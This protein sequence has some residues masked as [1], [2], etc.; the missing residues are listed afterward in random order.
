MSDI[1][2][3]IAAVS[4][5]AVQLTAERG[6]LVTTAGAAQQLDSQCQDEQIALTGYFTKYLKA[7]GKK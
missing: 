1:R 4:G 3:L 7:R 6:Q 2:Q 5:K